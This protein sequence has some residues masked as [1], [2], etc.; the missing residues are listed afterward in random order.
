MLFSAA[1]G[2]GHLHPLLPPA[3]AA[4]GGGRARGTRRARDGRVVADATRLIELGLGRTLAADTATPDQITLGIE[5]VLASHAM[6]KELAAVRR[7]REALPGPEYAVG[8][9][10]HVVER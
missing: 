3:A 2:L 4:G 9:I 1:G 6:R 5:D 10:E 8:A 7:E